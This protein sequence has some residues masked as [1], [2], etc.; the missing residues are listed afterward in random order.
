L[1]RDGILFKDD[2]PGDKTFCLPVPNKEPQAPLVFRPPL[3]S[4]QLRKEGGR[5]VEIPRA[6][7]VPHISDKLWR[8]IFGQFLGSV[9]GHE[10]LDLEFWLS[11]PLLVVETPDE[12]PDP[13]KHDALIYELIQ[14]AL[15]EIPGGNCAICLQPILYKNSVQLACTH[16]FCYGCIRGWS[17]D[18]ESI[19][20]EPDGSHL[21]L[22]T[23][24]KVNCPC[25]RKEGPMLAPT[26]YP[27]VIQTVLAEDET[28]E[29]QLCHERY[30]AVLA[31][32]HDDNCPKVG[33]Y[34]GCGA[35]IERDAVA[36]HLLAHH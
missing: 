20:E 25:C 35:I 12:L 18:R 24:G 17:R 13:R 32:F 34:L 9:G 8:N 3:G 36:D 6:E 14:K 15:K 33:C 10:I 16:S 19:E 5:L 22:D 26:D 23:L 21:D 30:A 7:R 4:L 11:K 31:G 28:L 27:T 1:Y 29:C 2:R